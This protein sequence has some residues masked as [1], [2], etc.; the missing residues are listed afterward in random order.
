MSRRRIELDEPPA[1]RD[2]I[3]PARADLEAILGGPLADGAHTLVLQAADGQGNTSAAFTLSFTLDSVR[4]Y[5]ELGVFTQSGGIEVA[6][7]T[8]RMQE[9]RRRMASS[10]AW[11]IDAELVTP[12]EVKRLVPFINE[13]VI[14]GGFSTPGIG[15]VDSLRGGTLM[16]EK[17]QAMG[18]LIVAAGSE[19]TGIDV[20]NGRVKRVR[21][22][23]GDI[24]AEVVVITSGIWSPRIARMAGASIPLS[25][26]VHQM[27]SVGPVPLFADT[28]GEI[29]YPIVRDMDTNGYERQHGSDMEVGSSGTRT[30]SLRSN[31]R[32]CPRRSCPS[33]RRISTNRW[34]TRSS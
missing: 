5:K 3:R 18:A 29:K 28:V 23:Q 33:P 24:E 34:S 9:L 26:A 19:V 20:E 16:R 30:T 10:K 15:T 12:A 31:N 4:Q 21:T 13:D 25:P 22:D 8:E 11:G 6:R 14:L 1:H 32:S 7:T 2:F 27:I 17:A